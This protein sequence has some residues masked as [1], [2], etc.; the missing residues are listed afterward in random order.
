MD[1]QSVE[2]LIKKQINK[3]EVVFVGSRFIEGE[4]TKAKF[5][6]KSTVLLII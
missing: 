4:G 2:K 1:S 5:K 3:P 6:I